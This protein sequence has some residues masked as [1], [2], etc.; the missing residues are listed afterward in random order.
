MPANAKRILKVNDIIISKV[1]PYRGAI[2]LVD[3]DYI[4]S[5]AFTVLK[6]KDIINKETI[7]IFFRNNFMLNYINKFSTGTSYPVIVDEYIYNTYIP[8]IDKNVQ[9]IIADKVKEAYKSRDKAKAL[10][11]EAKKKVEDAIENGE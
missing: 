8:I 4:G 1:R 9:N 3:N 2:S 10:L 5:S 11:E 6:E 7:F